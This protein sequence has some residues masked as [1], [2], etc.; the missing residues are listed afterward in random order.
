MASSGPPRSVAR[1][2]RSSNTK[3]PGIGFRRCP[4]RGSYHASF[5]RSRAMRPDKHAH[6]GRRHRRVLAA[7]VCSYS[8]MAASSWPVRSWTKGGVKVDASR[9]GM[10]LP[11]VREVLD[12]FGC[13]ARSRRELPLAMSSSSDRLHMFT[14]GTALTSALVARAKRKACLTASQPVSGHR[15]KVVVVLGPVYGTRGQS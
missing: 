10:P 9:P 11:Q 15:A 3:S 6:R 13:Q 7:R 12:C 8:G 5:R 2:E 1:D 4:E 14:H